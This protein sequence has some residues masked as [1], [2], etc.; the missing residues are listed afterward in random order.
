M[1]SLLVS[2]VSTSALAEEYY[3]E[4]GRV[5]SEAE[6][7]DSWVTIRDANVK[8]LAK[9]DVYPNQIIQP[10][11]NFT[12][13]VQAGPMAS[14]PEAQ[15]VCRRL[16]RRQ[17]SCFL[18]EG[19]D[20]KNAQTFAAAAEKSPS[21]FGLE[22]FLPWAQKSPAKEV[23]PAMIAA[24]EAEKP[25]KKEEPVKLEDSSKAKAKVDV[26]EAIA[27]PVTESNEVT[28]GEATPVFSFDNIFSSS[29][30]PA[31]AATDTPGWLSVQPFLNEESANAFVKN[32]KKRNLDE[33][34][35]VETKIIHPTVSHD[36]PKVILALGS[37]PSEQAALKFC[38]DYVASS[39]YLE[40]MFSV[41]PPEGDEAGSA[42]A[43]NSSSH[44]PA[45]DEYSLFWVDVLSENSQDKAL[46]R[47]ERIR[48]DN[49]DLLSDVRSQITTSIAKAGTYT[50][51]IGPLKM[52]SRATKL[53]NA[54]KERKISCEVSSL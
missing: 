9:Y 52:K 48:T 3:V 1:L 43:R 51:R 27:V 23:P 20:P 26:A 15:R 38:R 50:V 25:V 21:K 17:V 33:M 45:A 36:I 5:N 6:A 40:C 19:F 37:F 8:I 30:T 16:F 42:A 39:R 53:C 44:S 2:L 14:K 34:K 24:P 46:E 49:D 41:Q 18:I 29:T 35:G 28:V 12:Y 10:D 11:G 13:R 7:R 54:L 4:L 47:W 31:V 32:L 22:D